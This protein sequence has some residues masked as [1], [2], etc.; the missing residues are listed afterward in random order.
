MSLLACSAEARTTEGL[1][2]APVSHG[3]HPNSEPSGPSR[4]RGPTQ[5]EGVS[6][7]SIRH[8][9]HPPSAHQRWGPQ[10]GT[11][12]GGGPWQA[13]AP[14]P[15]ARG[16]VSGAWPEPPTGT[17]ACS[18]HSR[19]SG[20]HAQHLPLLTAPTLHKRPTSSHWTSGETGTL[21]TQV[22]SPGSGSQPGF[23]ARSVRFP[24]PALGGFSRPGSSAS[25]WKLSEDICS[26][27]RPV[28][29]SD[30]AVGTHSCPLSFLT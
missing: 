8:E 13:P 23:K 26:Q 18:G 3:T 5:T 4:G 17:V 2:S 7:V 14:P 16:P 1:P 28:R 27:A 25:P 24:S 12:L 21:P 29:G 10:A 11:A 19:L 30:Q 6:V 22:V 9:G 15:W 20:P